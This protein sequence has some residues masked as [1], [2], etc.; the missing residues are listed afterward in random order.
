MAYVNDPFLS[1]ESNTIHEDLSDVVAILAATDTPMLTAL[2][3]SPV[4]SDEFDWVADNITQ[5]SAVVAVQQGAEVDSAQPQASRQRLRNF[6]HINRRAVQVS[7][8]ERVMNEVGTED[9]FSYEV[10]KQLLE[11]AMEHDYAITWSTFVQGAV[12]TAPQTHG[13]VPWI[14]YTGI[15]GS[16]VTI[17][18]QSIADTYSS[19][20]T[21]NAHGVPISSGT[22]PSG[23]SMTVTTAAPH[24]LEVG[25]TVRHFQ[26]TA[27]FGTSNGDFFT[28]LLTVTAVGSS[29]T[30]TIATTATGAYT[31][32]NSRTYGGTDITRDKLHSALLAPAA[33][34]KGVTIGQTLWFCGASV[35]RVFSRLP[36]VYAGSGATQS[37]MLLNDRNIP[38]EAKRLVDTIDVYE[39]DFG[40]LYINLNRRM[41]GGVYTDPTIEQYAFTVNGTAYY[42]M[43]SSTL[44]GIEP[45]YW[46]YATLRP[47]RYKDLADT[48]DRSTGMIVVE[49]GIKCLNPRAGIGGFGVAAA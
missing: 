28:A 31:A 3:H 21:Y 46:K 20:V 33:M 35:K 4:S 27:T 18:G 38:A 16:S 30:Y 6:T 1:F 9:L 11:C 49:G 42:V 23:G 25:D 34:S 43:P 13:I 12:G 37:S 5:P 15:D 2:E 10:E 47:I 39:S 7:D 14:F 24:G 32:N 45:R 41:N 48:G 44:I 40:P 17:A 36:L 22:T 19:T 29:T 8:T 26:G